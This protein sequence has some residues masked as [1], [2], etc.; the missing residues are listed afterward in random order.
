MAGS[1]ILVLGLVALALLGG[2]V[3]L[4]IGHRRWSWG[5][6]VAAFLVLLAAAGYLYLASR[7]ASRE[8]AWKTAVTRYETDIAR[9]RDALQPAADGGFV[10]IAGEKSI[11]TLT[12]ERDRW[13]RGLDRVE[14]WRTRTWQ[15]AS[16]QPPESDTGTGRLALAAEGNADNRPPLAVGAHVFLFDSAPFED[17]GRYIGEF[18]VREATFDAAAKRHVL[19]VAQAAP[20]DG[21]DTR[22]FARD[23]ESVTVFESLP[24]DRWLAFYRCRA[25]EDES[26]SPLPETRKEADDRVEAVLA[27]SEQVARLVRTFIDTFKQHEQ[28]VPEDQWAAVAASLRPG[29]DGGPATAIPG[30]FWAEVEFDRPH[31]FPAP[32]GASEDDL[33]REYEPGDRA[34]FDLETALDLRDAAKAGRILRVFHRRPLTDA[35]TALYGGRIETAAAGILADGLTG[36][37]RRLRL[38]LAELERSEERLR[39]ARATAED[40][41]ARTADLGQQLAADLESWRKD[42]QAATQLADAFARRLEETRAER[43][44]A[45]ERIVTLGRELRAAFGRLAAEIDRVAPAARSVPAA[46][47]T[48]GP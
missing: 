12:A 10:P 6:V 40:D 5:T 19:S 17:G 39:Q 14:T 26:G 44:A 32:A 41:R 21:Y 35:A 29:P 11:A 27:Q 30:T 2:L 34:E 47:T 23:Y 16:F 15:G 3:A 18:I 24:V 42:A 46:S 8:L 4:G 1:E 33:R 13:R 20:R 43:G 38:E 31:A 45:E 36:L 9:V 25:A 28:P 37:V 48:V 22:A 7:L